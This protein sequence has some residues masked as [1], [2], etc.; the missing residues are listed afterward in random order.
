MNENSQLYT[1]N[2]TSKEEHKNFAKKN[3]L[4]NT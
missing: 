1:D 2:I 3:I 4:K